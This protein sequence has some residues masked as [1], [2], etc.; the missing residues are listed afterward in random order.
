MARR[1]AIILSSW[2]GVMGVAVVVVAGTLVNESIQDS[3]RRYDRFHVPNGPGPFP[4]VI[5][6]HACGGPSGRDELWAEQFRQWGYLVLRVNSFAPRGLK[7]VCGGG[8]FSPQERVADVFDALTHLRSKRD[9]DP[10]RIAIAGWSHG[11]STVLMTMAAASEEPEQRFRAAIAFYPGCRGVPPWRARIPTL[12]LLGEIDDWTPSSPCEELSLRQRSAGL[13]VRHVT[14]P[15]AHHGFDNPLR[16]TASRRVPEA[17]GGRGATMQYNQAAAEDS[18]VQVQKFLATH[19]Q[20]TLHGS[21][22][23]P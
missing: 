4:A 3:I 8:I 17:R 20:P 13:D 18:V 7:S 12:M 16:G 14:Y 6:L 15:G 22:V 9:V 10:T 1:A 5:L 19:L 11:G 23:S 2:L 21:P